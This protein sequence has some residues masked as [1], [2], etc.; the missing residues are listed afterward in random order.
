[1]TLNFDIFGTA[2]AQKGTK[3]VTVYDGY[4]GN[5][6]LVKV[7]YFDEEYD[8]ISHTRGTCCKPMSTCRSRKSAER[9]VNRFFNER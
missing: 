6:Y 1:M 7:M 4:D 9:M 5:K 3:R 8:R 2:K